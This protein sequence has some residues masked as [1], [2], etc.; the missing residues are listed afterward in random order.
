MRVLESLWLWWHRGK[1]RG[2]MDR[3]FSR[4]TDPFRYRES[5]YERARLAA[6]EEALEGRRYARALELGCAEGDFTER[7]CVAASEVTAVDISGVAL[8]RARERLAGR[9]GLR[10]VEADLR[11]WEPPL[12]SAFDLIV[13]GDVLYYLDKPMGRGAFEAAFP[14]V[15]GWLGEGGRLILAHAFAGERELSRRRAFRERFE[16]RGLRLEAES[17]VEASDG[18]VRCLL[19]ILQK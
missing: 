2:K 19:S 5:P 18:P 11:S 7:L 17:V 6:M 9:P 15:A 12:G 3:V 16:G 14:R 1:T 8:S 4:G 10:F 13:L